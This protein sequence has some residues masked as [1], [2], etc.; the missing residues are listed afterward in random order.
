M[1]TDLM[2][3]LALN[4]EAGRI[5]SRMSDGCFVND[6]HA[7]YFVFLERNVPPVKY[8]LCRQHLKMAP[9][10]LR[11]LSLNFDNKKPGPTSLDISATRLSHRDPVGF[12]PHPREWLS[13]IEY[14]RTMKQ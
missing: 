6:L 10:R 3:I 9:R 5:P 12:P 7:N 13:I 2:E 4:E 11:L 1:V 8:Y 14:H